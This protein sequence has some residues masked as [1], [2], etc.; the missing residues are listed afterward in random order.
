MLAISNKHG[1]TFVGCADGMSLSCS[2]RWGYFDNTNPQN[3]F[4]VNKLIIHLTQ[5]VKGSAHEAEQNV[6]QCYI[7]FLFLVNFT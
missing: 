7:F 1:L 5:C 2:V 3:S 6:I 4:L